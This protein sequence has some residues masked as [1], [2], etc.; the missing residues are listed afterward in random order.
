MKKKQLPF[1]LSLIYNL[2]IVGQNSTDNYILT[3][4]YIGSNEQKIKTVQ[5]YDG[6]GRPTTTISNGI[7]G[8]GLSVYQYNIY[9]EAGLVYKT[10]LPIC[11][12]ISFSSVTENEIQGIAQ[13][14]YN[15]TRNYTLT[16]YDAIDRINGKQGP[17]AAWKDNGKK[18]A[19]S[20]GAN[21]DKS[22]KLYEAPYGDKYSLVQNG[23][24]K[25]GT[26]YSKT[27]VDED[28]NTVE[29][30]TDKTGNL[31]LIRRGSD[32]DTYYVYNTLGQLRFILSPEYQ[33]SGYKSKFAYEYR[34]DNNGRVVKKILPGCEY[35]QYWYDRGDRITFMQD[36]ILRDKN[37]YRFFLYDKFGRQVIQ[38][39][40]DKQ[41]KDEVK[42]KFITVNY[43]SSKPGIC[44]TG[45]Y[46]EDITA[47]ETTELET[48]TFYDDYIFTKNKAIKSTLET[49]VPVDESVHTQNLMTGMLVKTSNGELLLK[50]FCYDHLGRTTNV[51]ETYPKNVYMQTGFQYSFTDNVTQKK[52]AL[53]KD[54]K[55]YYVITDYTYNKFNDKLETTTVSLNGKSNIVSNYTYSNIGPIES[56]Q[57][58]NKTYKTEYTYNNRGWIKSIDSK[59]F[60]E[61]I[62]YNDGIGE[63]Y[64]NGNISSMKWSTPDY[65]QVR[66]YKFYYDQLDRLKEA[67]YGEREDLTNKE[68]RYNEKVIEYN[69]NGMI[70]HF[71]RR[72]L[73]DN[74]EYG[75]IDNL[76][77]VLDGNKIQKITDDALPVM[78]YSSLEFRDYAN[79][80]VEYEYNGNGA[81]TRDLNRN[82]IN[83]KYD[84]LCHPIQIMFKDSLDISYSYDALGN[85]LK[86]RYR[87]GDFT[88]SESLIPVGSTVPVN[89]N[90]YIEREYYGNFEFYN[91]EFYKYIFDGGYIDNSNDVLK[92]CFFVKDHIGSN[93]TVFDEDNNIIQQM[94]YYPFGGYF[95]DA[96]LSIEAQGQLYSGKEIEHMQGLNTYD[97]GAR[98]YY[99]CFPIWDRIDSE[100]EKHPE[101]SPY[102]FCNCNPIK[103]ADNDGRDYK[104]TINENVITV[105]AK[106]SAMEED[107]DAALEAAQFINNLSGKFAWQIKDGKTR[108]QLPIN[109]DISIE[110]VTERHGNKRHSLQRATYEEKEYNKNIFMFKDDFPDP[111][112]NGGTSIG[113]DIEVRNNQDMQQTIV[114]EFLHAMGMYHTLFGIMT[115]G[116]EDIGRS[117]SIIEQNITDL[118]YGVLYKGYAPPNA[119]ENDIKNIG[120]GILSKIRDIEETLLKKG[121]AIK[122]SP[123]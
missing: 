112:K 87:V 116:S 113:T 104:V 123:I 37:K 65:G 95:A 14:Q 17:G 7:G 23:Y 100:C 42:D 3:E 4:R 34:Y 5:L 101:T 35:I 94:H 69:A 41:T 53:T 68:N 92:Y 9:N 40:C 103:Y 88:F 91:G 102:V 67:V 54:G 33:H 83:I 93:R 45:Y 120:K 89:N 122:I 27:T 64:Y 62:F 56:F 29:E 60:S 115:P 19:I 12:G 98:Q 10:Y 32:N 52:E 84:Y 85:K 77:I 18:L 110:K 78:K 80:P 105:S 79:E 8:N 1:I 121:K 99:P 70:K 107:Y 72:G 75:K 36:A 73:K 22:V 108:R 106:I 24:Y 38:G 21:A 114:H 86:T 55:T 44:S 2:C 81:L 48:A 76:N 46:T 39:L 59:F 111:N 47:Y 11:N 6:L 119:T 90:I 31:I 16:E 30:F 43:D 61:R 118:M 58:N 51:L 63:P 109:F 28:G 49:N 26:L 71:Q 15:D 20:Y 82:I 13:M 97:F 50:A 66:G 74:G 96:S 25:A 117:N 57:Q